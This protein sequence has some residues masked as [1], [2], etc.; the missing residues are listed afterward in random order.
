MDGSSPVPSEYIKELQGQH[1]QN[2]CPSSKYATL[3]FACLGLNHS[4]MK[5]NTHLFIDSFNFFLNLIYD[6]INNDRKI[7]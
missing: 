5:T 4:G 2:H 1:G 6:Q 3:L 7:E